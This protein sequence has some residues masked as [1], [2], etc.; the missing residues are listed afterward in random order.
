MATLSSIAR[1]VVRGVGILVP[2]T[3]AGSSDET[4][5]RLLEAAQQAGELLVRARPWP[6]LVTELT[7]D[8]VVDQV[9]YTLPDDFG[10]LI[11]YTGWQPDTYWR[12]RGNLTPAQW[13]T[14]Q[15]SLVAV[16]PARLGF[17]VR[18]VSGARE[19]HLTPAPTSIQSVVIE[20][21]SRNFCTSSGG[22][23][24]SAWVSDTDIPLLDEDLFVLATRWLFKESSGLP[25]A[26]DY[27]MYMSQLKSAWMGEL[28]LPVVDLTGR[29]LQEYPAIQDGDWGL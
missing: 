18:V 16:T 5:Q 14:E 2:S 22:T 20:Y 26:V 24:Q 4:A 15:N 9:A 8:T 19:L 6:A 21:V 25:F 13:Q 27:E 28:A 10:R 29:R 1:R 12:M 23:G 17:R 11:P 7:F 3:I